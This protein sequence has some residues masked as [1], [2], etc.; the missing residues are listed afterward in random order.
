MMSSTDGCSQP[1][2]FADRRDAGRQ[3][4]QPLLSL[5]DESPVVVGLPRG[6]IPVAA[7]V[8]AALGA[9]LE[10]LAVRKLGAP[11]NPEHGIGAIAEDGTS[12]FDSEALASLGIG[13]SVLKA[14]VEREIEELHRRVA[15]YRGNRPPPRLE[16]H[17]VIVVDDG[18]ATGVTDAAALRSIQRQHPRRLILAVPVCPPDSAVRLSEEADELVCLAVPAQ[19]RGVSEWYQD[20]SQVHDHEVKAAIGS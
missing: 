17:T 5:A 6:G 3:L 19:L 4:A 10:L 20:F 8:A 11:Q 14:I 18:V 2:C 13:I 12:V 16:G 1:G 9:R 15:A 7:E